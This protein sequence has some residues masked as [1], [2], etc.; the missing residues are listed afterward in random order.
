MAYSYDGTNDFCSITTVRSGTYTTN[1]PFSNF[2][3]LQWPI[4]VQWASSDLARFSPASAP[5]LVE[6]QTSSTA[7]GRSTSSATAST[8]TSA[9]SV[10]AA[11]ATSS[12][13]TGG[14]GL[15]TGAQAGIGAGIGALALALIGLG[16]WFL[17][18]RRRDKKSQS[19]PSHDETTFGGMKAELPGSQDTRGYSDKKGLHG[20]HGDAIELESGRD[21]LN[22]LDGQKK[23]RMEP[24][25]LP[26]SAVGEHAAA[27]M[28]G[29][30]SPVESDGK[31]ITGT[32]QQAAAWRS[33][34][35]PLVKHG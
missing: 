3:A 30:K 34:R 29:M 11:A 22:E 27:E 24:A 17:L 14:G 18:R 19:P 16:I 2:I 20:Q 23:Q 6:T 25:E 4:S 31:A 9:S 33:N 35:E 12:A 13:A 26:G 32:E 1:V 21:G 8:T 5:V 15:S 28:A 10:D 7:S